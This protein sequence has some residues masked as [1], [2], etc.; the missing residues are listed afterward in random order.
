MTNLLQRLVGLAAAI[1]LGGCAGGHASLIPAASAATFSRSAADTASGLPGTDTASGLPGTDTASGLPGTDT[2]SGLPGTDTAS[3]LPGDT[4]TGLPGANFACAPVLA[5]GTA[6]CTL[7]I[8]LNVPPVASVANASLI[9]GL[10]PSDLQSAY[11]LPSQDRGATV[12]IVD[13]YDNPAVEADLAV[14]RAAFG[15][16]PCTHLTG[17]FT[18]LNQ[19]GVAGAYP[20][21]NAAWSEEI[22]LDVEMVSAVCPNCAILLIETDSALVDDL[23]A[24]V[25]TAVRLGARVVSNSY[26][27]TEWAGERNEDVHYDHPGT[28]LAVASGDIGRTSYPAASSG[29]TAVGGTSLSKSGGW[30]E[31]AWQYG[32]HGCSPYEAKPRWQAIAPCRSR[33]AVDISAVADPQTGVA[34]FEAA[35]GG[36]LVAG[37]T[38]VSTPIVAAA[39]ALSGDPQSPAYLYEHRVDFR[40]LTSLAY[41]LSTGLG[42]PRGIAGL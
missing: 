13:A 42:S 35:A 6:R 26:Y 40:T 30:S 5:A 41:D 3:G 39:F 18:K 10:H 1:A 23:G 4:A 17:C 19:R 9:A 21:A 22:S 7:A 28:A 24:G 20:A 12:A 34:M 32:G 31:R 29:V 2:A 14:Y 37:G 36:W 15:L 8:N 33:S 11:Q 25:D 27:A 16:G 38:S